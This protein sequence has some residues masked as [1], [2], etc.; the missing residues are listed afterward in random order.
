MKHMLLTILAGAF[1]VLAGCEISAIQGS[2][3]FNETVQ[4]EKDDAEELDV[5]LTLGAGELQL[6]GGSSEWLTGD[7]RYKPKRLKPEITYTR[8]GETGIITLNQ[9][10]KVDISEMDNEWDIQLTNKVPIDL[11]VHAGASSSVLNL[12]GMHLEKVNIESGVGELTVDMSGDWKQSFAVNLDAGVG[13]T[14]IIVPNET[15]V[16][17][18]AEMG[19][20]ETSFKD[21]ISKGDGIYVN[22]AYTTADTIITIHTNMGIGATTFEMEK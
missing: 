16:I 15:G 6:E 7:I 13:D 9:K 20:G 12:A 19:L 11:T 4:V 18:E 21:F 3:V 14:T 17:I 5:A 10:K 1:L 22:K 8:S 2:E